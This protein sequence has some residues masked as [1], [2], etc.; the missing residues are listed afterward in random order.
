MDEISKIEQQVGPPE[1]ESL[2]AISEELRKQ[3]AAYRLIDK[4]ERASY[5]WNAVLMAFGAF[6]VMA[7][8]LLVITDVS[9]RYLFNSPIMGALEVEQIMLAFVAFLCLAYG[10]VQRSHLRVTLVTSRLS[11]RGQVIAELFAGVAGLAFFIL[12]SWG[13]IE[14]FWT[15]WQI[16]EIMPAAIKLPYWLPK[17][18]MMTGALLM[19]IQFGL[20]TLHYLVI[21]VSRKG[22][23]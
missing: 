17:L 11:Q 23:A 4:I 9:G 19:T 22:E 1:G 7:I 12:M 6:L 5:W 13:A 14:Q 21:L 3:S 8:M 10:L 2:E 15:S 16:Q 18:A 20:Y